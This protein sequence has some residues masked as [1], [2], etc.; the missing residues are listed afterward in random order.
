MLAYEQ[1]PN[2]ELKIGDRHIFIRRLCVTE[3]FRRK[4]IATHLLNYLSS[5]KKAKGYR[6]IALQTNVENAE[7][8]LLYRKLDFTNVAT[9]KAGEHR[10]NIYVIDAIKLSHTTQDLI[11]GSARS[12][13]EAGLPLRT[14]ENEN[15]DVVMAR[16]KNEKLP[17][18]MTVFDYENKSIV[19]VDFWEF[20]ASLLNRQEWVFSSKDEEEESIKVAGLSDE[21]LEKVFHAMIPYTDIPKEYSMQDLL[22]IMSKDILHFFH[23]IK[24]PYAKEC[25]AMGGVGTEYV[26]LALQHKII[27]REIMYRWNLSASSAVKDFSSSISSIAENKGGIAFTALPIQTESV[28][29]SALGALTGARAFRGDLDVEWVQI[30]AVFNAGIRP[31][32][33]RLSEYTAA[34][35][36]SPLAQDKIDQ[37]RGML[38]DILRRE[39]EDDK[40]RLSEPALKKLLSDLEGDTDFENKSIEIS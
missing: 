20:V 14:S 26:K 29:S 6:P 31:S 25:M 28:A 12:A 36:A 37:V 23:H 11:I 34:A 38:A 10:D 39:E 9:I 1:E 33:Q 32:V 21:D 35:S 7:A 3:E 13:V 4:H 15:L 22:D 16:L 40:L 30:Q 27:L 18:K 8:N 24:N 5:Q 17:G 19:E 2:N